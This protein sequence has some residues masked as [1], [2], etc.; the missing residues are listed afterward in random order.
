MGERIPPQTPVNAPQS[1]SE[2]EGLRAYLEMVNSPAFKNDQMR[3]AYERKT[4]P[5]G[6]YYGNDPASGMTDAQYR[7]GIPK[8]NY[9]EMPPTQLNMG[10][11]NNVAAPTF[12]GNMAGGMNGQGNVAGQ[13]DYL[14]K[15]NSGILPGAEGSMN[16]ASDL[17]DKFRNKIDYLVGGF[18][19][20]GLSVSPDLD[21]L[22]IK[23]ALDADTQ[24]N[25][26]GQDG[27][28]KA[29]YKKSF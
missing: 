19:P 14:V 28:I 11:L 24:Y 16:Y 20:D 15:P 1:N 13:F 18:L 29:Q 4:S 3:E 23:Y 21:K 2:L 5:D 8:P 12:T 7:Q 26:S 22:K 25:L 9:L 17:K 10:A 27:N 6:V